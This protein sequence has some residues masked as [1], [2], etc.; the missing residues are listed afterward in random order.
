[1]GLVELILVLLPKG[2]K[3]FWHGVPADVSAWLLCGSFFNYYFFLKGNSTEPGDKSRYAEV[4]VYR[5]CAQE[6]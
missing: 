1:M 3:L 5:E 2:F 6:R 4:K